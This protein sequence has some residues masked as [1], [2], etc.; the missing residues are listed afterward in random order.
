MLD[1]ETTLTMTLFEISF[2][3]NYTVEKIKQQ[4]L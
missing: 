2:V 3:V 1:P 4:D